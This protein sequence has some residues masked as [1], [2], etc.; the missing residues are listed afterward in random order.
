MT[1][2][3]ALTPGI[4]G[5]GGIDGV[6][7]VGG[8]NGVDGSRGVNRV[9]EIDWGQRDWWGHGS[10]EL[11]GVEG[12]RVMV[13]GA[14]GV[15]RGQ[16]SGVT[17]LGDAGA[18]LELQVVHVKLVVILGAPAS[19]LAPDPRPLTLAVPPSIAQCPR[20]PSQCPIDPPSPPLT[21]PV[22]S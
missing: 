10:T 21:V 13:L 17:H 8:A 4:N 15:G 19:A 11:N 7:G 20:S 3:M 18:V 6:N 5:V 9:N 14:G 12:E 2:V 22:A 16:R 1:G